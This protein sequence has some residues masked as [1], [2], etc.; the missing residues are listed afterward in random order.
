MDG[1]AEDPLSSRLRDFSQQLTA[2]HLEDIVVGKELFWPIAPKDDT[3]LPSWPKLTSFRL[4]YTITTPSGGWYFE[5]NPAEE[6]ED[7]D[8]GGDSDLEDQYSRMQEHLRPPLEDRFPQSSRTKV[9]SELINEFYV[10]AGR[11]A[12]RMPKLKY[13]HLETSSGQGRHWF[14]YE[15]KGKT[16]T[17]TWADMILFQPEERVL[18]VWRDAARQHTGSESNLE[19]KL[20]D[21]S[22]PYTGSYA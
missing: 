7:A 3:Q 13:M 1:N 6:G 10:S 21:L 16:A 12:Q 18:E 14:Q 2:I 5:R 8:G 15:V 9:S 22:V 4:Q 19:V 20:Q 11:A 17:A